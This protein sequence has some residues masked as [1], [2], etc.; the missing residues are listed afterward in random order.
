MGLKEGDKLIPQE[1]SAQTDF[2]SKVQKCS[3]TPLNFTLTVSSSL[4]N[5]HAWVQ[6][7]TSDKAKLSRLKLGTLVYKSLK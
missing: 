7:N 6:V 5:D 2:A 1:I 3:I 4:G